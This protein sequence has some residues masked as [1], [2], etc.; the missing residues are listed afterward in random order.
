MQDEEH[1]EGEAVKLS[2]ADDYPDDAFV[3]LGHADSE[4][5]DGNTSFDRHI[6]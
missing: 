1:E 6:A 2:N 5:K 3:D 4:Q